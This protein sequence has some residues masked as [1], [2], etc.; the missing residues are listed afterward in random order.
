MAARQA[1]SS[2]CSDIEQTDRSCG[3]AMALLAR[4]DQ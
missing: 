1:P 4:M 3:A 2:P